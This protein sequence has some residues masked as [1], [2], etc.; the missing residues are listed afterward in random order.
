MR[1][2]WAHNLRVPRPS[3]GERDRAQTQI[4]IYHWAW[5]AVSIHIGVTR[6]LVKPR[7][8]CIDRAGC[9]ELEACVLSHRANI[10]QYVVH[11]ILLYISIALSASISIAIDLSRSL[12]ENEPDFDRTHLQHYLHV[13]YKEAQATPGSKSA[14]LHSDPPIAHPRT[15]DRSTD[16]HEPTPPPL[17]PARPSSPQQRRAFLY[18]HAYAHCLFRPIACCLLYLYN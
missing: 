14:I 10:V 9:V 18:L 17:A 11:I 2:L 13:C 16:P 8:S 4:Y 15:R 1:E 5:L 3:R 6:C 7:K 12:G